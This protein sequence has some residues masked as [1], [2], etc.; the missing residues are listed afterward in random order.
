MWSEKTGAIES[1]MTRTRVP[2]PIAIGLG[3]GGTA[4]AGEGAN[5]RKEPGSAAASEKGPIGEEKG[6]NAAA[7]GADPWG[8]V[9]PSALRQAGEK[10]ASKARKKARRKKGPEL[11]GPLQM[12]PGSSSPAAN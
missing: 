5:N 11:I 12:G 9:A 1:P 2:L 6:E 10:I 4:A 3:G 8:G 7:L